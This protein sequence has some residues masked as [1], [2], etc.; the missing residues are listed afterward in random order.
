MT[1]MYQDAEVD[2]WPAATVHLDDRHIVLTDE[3]AEYRFGSRTRTSCAVW[4]LRTPTGSLL[5]GL[6]RRSI[7]IIGPSSHGLG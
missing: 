4:Q 3:E 1:A 7:D 2:E 5:P 6:T